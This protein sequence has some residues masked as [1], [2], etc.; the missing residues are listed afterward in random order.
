MNVEQIHGRWI[1]FSGTLRQGWGI[2]VRSS[3]AVDAGRS[4]C[5]EGRLALR[6]A[7]EKLDAKRQLTEF[8]SRN[9]IWLDL[10][11]R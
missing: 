6:S 10:T 5:R 8:A 2:L 4:N 9:R 3:H 11:S 7:V 1:Q